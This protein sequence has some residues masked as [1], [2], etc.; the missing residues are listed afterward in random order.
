MI[1]DDIERRYNDPE[2]WLP[3]DTAR[4]AFALLVAG[5]NPVS[6]DGRDYPGLPDRVLPLDE[7]L[8]LLRGCPQTT[9]DAVW[10]HLVRRARTEGS[11]WT[12]ACVGMALP[13]LAG[14]A[15]DLDAN[16]SGDLADIHAEVLTGFLDALSTI[17]LDHPK[18]LIGL[19]WAAYRA[20]RSALA[21]AL[22]A[23]TPTAS[24]FRSTTPT[25]P[26]GHP[27]LVLARAVAEGVLNRTE[28]DLIGTTRLEE[29]PVSDWAAEHGV[30]EWAAYKS[31]NR[32][33]HRLIAFL[34][35]AVRHTDPEDPVAEEVARS[36]SLNRPT[37]RTPEFSPSVTDSGD[38]EQKGSREKVAEDVSKK[39]RKT[40]LLECGETM[41]S[42]RPTPPSED[43]C[44]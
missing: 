21:R 31:R 3:L 43:R 39:A 10:A 35:D 38:E 40:G 37:P 2:K 18:I 6:L 32:A 24:G 9:R 23:P 27:D 16:W 15:R 29:V 8:A 7:V 34:R 19:R 1:A 14:V 20:G 44:A 11:T 36:L 41:P 33:E 22:D 5:P 12:V 4:N 30:S 42:P 17:D 25:P 13:A 26:W 28:A